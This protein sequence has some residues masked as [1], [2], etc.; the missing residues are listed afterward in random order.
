VW[1]TN[2]K[3]LSYVYIMAQRMTICTSSSSR[4]MKNRGNASGKAL[5]SMASL[6]QSRKI[7]LPTPKRVLMPNQRQTANL[8]V[9]DAKATAENVGDTETLSGVV[10]RPFKEVQSQL[11]TVTNTNTNT[12]TTSLARQNFSDACEAALNDQINVE[13]NVSYVYHA[14]HAYFDRDYIGLPGMA[15]YFKAQSQ[16]EREHAELFMEYL[17]KRGGKVKLQSIM[18]P[19]MEFAGSASGDALYAM[20]LTLSLEKL[21]NEKLLSLHKTAEDSCDPQMTDFVEGNFL[22]EQ[23]QAIKD[24]STMVSQLRRVGQ[25]HGVYHFD[26]QLQ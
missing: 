7:A 21:V 11:A 15:K 16:E 24:V 1:K 6:E 13:F 22:D 9:K 10:F 19:D 23:V 2:I 20:E 18:M 25:G 12:N 17:N 3:L 26:L 8:R 4:M 5:S 14:L